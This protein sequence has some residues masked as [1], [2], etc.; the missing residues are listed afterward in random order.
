MLQ[1]H[2][3]LELLL[4]DWHRGQYIPHYNTLVLT[5]DFPQRVTHCD[6]VRLEDVIA[7]AKAA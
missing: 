4:A 6:V 7:I 5:A 3:G 1:R 2:F